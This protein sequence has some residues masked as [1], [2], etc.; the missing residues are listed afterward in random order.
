MRMRCVLSQCVCVCVVGGRSRRTIVE[1]LGFR[2]NFSNR[3]APLDSC[4]GEIR[5]TPRA[6]PEGALR[7]ASSN[8]QSFALRPNSA[9]ARLAAE[10]AA[11]ILVD[12]R[13]LPMDFDPAAR[14]G[15]GVGGGGGSNMAVG[16]I[17]WDPILTHFSGDWDVHSGYGLLT[18]GHIETQQIPQFPEINQC[19]TCIPRNSIR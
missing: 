11:E 19:L 12:D 4:H 17:L 18:H 10:M 9:L 5:A 1:N 16:Q 3:K 15:G 6:G 13:P 2:P 14:G 8:V 7:I